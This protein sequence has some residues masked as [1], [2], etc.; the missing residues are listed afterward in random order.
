M[1]KKI[2]SKKVIGIVAAM[3]LIS[4][5]LMAKPVMKKITAHL[6]S[7]ITYAYDGKEILKDVNSITYGNKTYVPVNEFARALG[8]DVSY[9]NG[10]IIVTSKVEEI[11]QITIDKSVIKE[12]NK[13]NNQVTIL[14]AGR[15]DSYENY[16]I[17]NV[18]PNTLLRHEKLK[19]IVVLNDL[20]VGMEVKVA[21][22][23][24]ST[25]SLPPQ[26]NAF[27]MVIYANSGTVT[28]PD[29]E[30]DQNHKVSMGTVKEVNV[31][32]NQVTILPVGQKDSYENYIVLN[33]SD[34]TLL[35]NAK[36]GKLLNLKDLTVG[37]KVKA[38]HSQM[39]TFSL[40]PQTPTY[41]IIVIDKWDTG[42]DDD[43][44]DYDLEDAVIKQ[45]NHAEKYLVVVADG[46]EYKVI[47][48]NKTKVEYDKGNK[49]PN[50]N[51]LK[52]GQVIDIEVE[53]GVAEEIEVQN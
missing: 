20:E 45:I 11:K 13:Q 33:V 5:P 30:D 21:H 43:K 14:P 53:D 7:A 19:K 8:K 49:K 26:T 52:V 18:G 48:T 23:L 16:I 3:S 27:E 32:G 22:S 29:E 9:K 47:F 6:N 44:E 41:K 34:Q 37:M 2:L 1:N 39:A 15:E 4:V 42:K 28:T 17:L 50:V 31:A 25:S 40:P 24:V 51:S 12:I 10:K 36:Q 35:K 46:K 38:V